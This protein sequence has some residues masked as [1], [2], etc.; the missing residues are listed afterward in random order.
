MAENKKRNIWG[1]HGLPG[2]VIAV[3]GLIGMVIFLQL[4]VIVAYR[5][6]AAAP[7]DEGPIRDINNLKMIDDMENQNK[8]GFQPLKSE[9]K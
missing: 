9:T 1:L 8:F 3:L 6:G 5:H 7:Y 4:M 2:M